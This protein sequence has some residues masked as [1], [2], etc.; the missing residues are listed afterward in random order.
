MPHINVWGVTKRQKDLIKEQQ[1]ERLESIEKHKLNNGF[2]DSIQNIFEN[3][4][5]LVQNPL[6][7]SSRGLDGIINTGHVHSD[8]SGSDVS[9]VIKSNQPH[10]IDHDAIH[11]CKDWAAS[12][13]DYDQSSLLFVIDSMPF[14]GLDHEFEISSNNGVIPGLLAEDVSPIQQSFNGGNAL[15]SGIQI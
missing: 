2:V 12:P 3:R 5:L 1:S 11:S 15:Q 7:R 6:L 13:L 14:V 8:F 10:K 9:M 4:E